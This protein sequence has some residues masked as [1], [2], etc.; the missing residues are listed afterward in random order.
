MLIAA[1]A[2]VNQSK[3]R[4]I[5]GP[6]GDAPLYVAARYGHTDVCRILLAAGAD[7]NKQGEVL[8]ATWRKSLYYGIAIV[9]ATRCY[10]RQL[11]YYI[12]VLIS[13]IS[14][15]HC[16]YFLQSG[17]APLHVAARC[18]KTEVCRILLEAGADANIQ[19]VVRY[20][21]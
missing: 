7:V 1:G 17:D 11:F 9:Y 20:A 16:F 13:R 12:S 2:D 21:S 4:G 19:D 6:C 10:F 5:F 3:W 8:Y 14:V 18:G 15:M